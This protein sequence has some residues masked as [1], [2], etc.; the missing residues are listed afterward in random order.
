MAERKYGCVLLAGG[1]GS[2]MGGRNK[3][4]LE[5]DRQTFAERIESQLAGTGM[6]CY[7]SAA[8]YEQKLPDGWK[9]VRDCVSGEDGR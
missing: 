6:P 3:A 9:M 4:E 2:R 1:S 7:L 8:A 5:Y